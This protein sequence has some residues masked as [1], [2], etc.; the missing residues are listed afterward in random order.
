MIL[1]DNLNTLANIAGTGI[2]GAL[3][4]ISLKNYEINKKLLYNSKNDYIKELIDNQN[5]IIILLEEI[6]NKI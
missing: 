1:E 3:L 5:K 2:A 6:N 4:D